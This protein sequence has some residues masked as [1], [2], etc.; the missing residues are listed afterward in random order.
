MK[1]SIGLLIKE[2]L[3]HCIENRLKLQWKEATGIN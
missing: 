1:L 3:N 2:N